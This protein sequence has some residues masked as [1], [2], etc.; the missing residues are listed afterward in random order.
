MNDLVRDF[1]ITLPPKNGGDCVFQTTTVESCWRMMIEFLWLDTVRKHSFTKR[2]IF[3][4]AT[5]FLG[6]WQS[7]V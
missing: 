4:R 2:V 7:S 5:F 6:Y 3:L 1:Y